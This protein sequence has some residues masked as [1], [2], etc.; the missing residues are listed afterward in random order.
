MCTAFTILQCETKPGEIFHATPSVHL[1]AAIKH[2]DNVVIDALLA[3]P[4]EQR[5]RYLLSNAP[6]GLTGW[7]N[8]L[9]LHQEI[10]EQTIYGRKARENSELVH[11]SPAEWHDRML[12]Q[13]IPIMLTVL[14]QED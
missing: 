1:V 9:N 5:A 8:A 2:W 3:A 10:L 14:E 11:L 7:T 12:Y 13:T 6:V 4:T